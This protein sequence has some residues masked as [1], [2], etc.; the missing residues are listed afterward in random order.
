MDGAALPPAGAAANSGGAPGGA[1]DPAAASAAV[2]PAVLR[3]Y[4]EELLPLVLGGD[5]HGDRAD[6]HST[7]ADGA[8]A[9]SKFV[10]DQQCHVLYIHK[11][12]Y[13]ARDGQ[14]PV[15]VPHGTPNTVGTLAVIKT[16]SVID[17]VRPLQGQLQLTNLPGAASVDVL[18]G[19]GSG[20]YEALHSYIHYAVSPFFNAYVSSKQAPTDTTATRARDEKDSK[21]GAH[22]RH[23]AGIPM[24]KKKIAELELSL[25]H[26]QQ[27]VEIPD[28]SLTI[29]PAVQRAVNQVSEFA[30][31]RVQ[32]KWNPRLTQ[33]TRV[34]IDAVEPKLLADSS[35]QNRLQ[36]DVNGWIKE[37]QKVTNLS[38]D[39]ASGTAIQE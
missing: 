12:R 8:G 5:T 37:I 4:L 19:V 10:S 9:L 15:K 22:V 36:A 29:H 30:A 34:V 18:G 6:S 26:L 32:P 24:T 16:S 11:E 33:G 35:F 27:N 14:C 28:I 23:H 31:V 7:L 13:G 1:L 21:L 25:L 2:D 17:P 20:P 3:R 39:P 38:R